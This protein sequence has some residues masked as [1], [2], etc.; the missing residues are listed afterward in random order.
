MVLANPADLERVPAAVPQFVKGPALEPCQMSC[1][2]TP[3]LSFWVPDE[4]ARGPS[5]LPLPTA[6]HNTGVGVPFITMSLPPLLFFVIFVQK[7]C[8]QLSGRL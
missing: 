2:F 1:P 5:I 7:L 3:R 6:V 4:S 8:R